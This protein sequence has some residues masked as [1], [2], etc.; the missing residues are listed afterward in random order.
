MD[1]TKYVYEFSV[2]ADQGLNNLAKNMALL[3]KNLNQVNNKN[4]SIAL[5]NNANRTN[6]QSQ[7]STERKPRKSQKSQM[8]SQSDNSKMSRNP[9][10][11]KDKLEDSFTN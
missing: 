10:L 5:S 7:D 2:Q 6:I 8:K 1:F 11:K 4:D 9:G 3:H